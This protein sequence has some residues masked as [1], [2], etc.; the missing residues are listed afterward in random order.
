MPTIYEIWV[1]L[2]SPVSINCVA[3]LIRISLI[4]S[5]GANPVSAEFNLQMQQNSD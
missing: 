2:N 4:N 1:I 3:R 5:I